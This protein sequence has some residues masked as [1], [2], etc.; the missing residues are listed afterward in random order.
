MVVREPP[1]AQ[2]SADALL[3]ASLAKACTAFVFRTECEPMKAILAGWVQGI[4]EVSVAHG[5]RWGVGLR[6]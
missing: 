6:A 3:A 1:A 4:G 5:W 2:I